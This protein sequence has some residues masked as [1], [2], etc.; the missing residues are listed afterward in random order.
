MLIKRAL[1]VRGQFRM[2][3]MCSSNYVVC[4]E[5]TKS[6]TERDREGERVI[7]GKKEKSKRSFKKNL[8]LSVVQLGGRGASAE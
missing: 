8:C 1:T 4:S 6:E 5:E 3:T 7:V 2:S